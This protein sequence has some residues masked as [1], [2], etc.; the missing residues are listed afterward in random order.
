MEEQPCLPFDF[1][2]E[3]K[4]AFL[5][6]LPHYDNPENDNEILL[7]FQHDFL[8]NGDTAAL[9]KFYKLLKKIA[10]K[11]INAE[12]NRNKHIRGLPTEERK[13]KS[14]NAAM[15]MIEQLLSRQ[16]FYFGQIDPKTGKR[17]K[18]TGYLFLRVQHELYYETAAEKIQDFVDLGLFFKEGT[19][20]EAFYDPELYNEKTCGACAYCSQQNDGTFKCLLTF[21]AIDPR[22]SA[23]KCINWEE[24]K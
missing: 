16:Y 22:A 4:D 3:E 13:I 15:Y 21:E 2:Q 20:D 23:E 9:E 7:N 5:E 17:Q 10:Y 14:H 1:Y 11:L 12:T 18:P 19:E 6:A 8:K 24:A